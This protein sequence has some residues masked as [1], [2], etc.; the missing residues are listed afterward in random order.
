MFVSG[1]R[2]RFL[3]CKNNGCVSGAPVIFVFVFLF[4]LLGEL[5]V[6][7]HASVAVICLTDIHAC[8]RSF[9]KT[10]T[11]GEVLFVAQGS[12]VFHFGIRDG[13][14]TFPVKLPRVEFH[15]ASCFR[16]K[17]IHVM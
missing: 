14:G 6:G 3:K 4:L 13:I 12:A 1:Y 17:E 7:F 10:H 11:V 9:C 5:F 2:F 16:E 8:G 15:L